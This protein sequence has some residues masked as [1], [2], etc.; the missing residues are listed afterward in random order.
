MIRGHHLPSPIS[1]TRRHR[2]SLACLALLLVAGLLPTPSLAELT[3]ARGSGS[4]S[5]G[6]SDRKSTV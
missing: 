2:S 3:I 4:S 6:L 5:A 1:M